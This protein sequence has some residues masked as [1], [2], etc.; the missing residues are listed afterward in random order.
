M[1][2]VLGSAQSAHIIGRGLMISKG[3][4]GKS[5]Q[6]YMFRKY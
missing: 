5:R 1:V 4:W 3:N 2:T 6:E